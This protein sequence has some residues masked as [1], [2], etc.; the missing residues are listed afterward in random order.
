MELIN[1][2]QFG[3]IP[4]SSTLHAL[5]SM[6]PAWAQATDGTG[7]AVR[8]VLLDY[9]ELELFN[10]NLWKD[11]R[12]K[13]CNKFFEPTMSNTEHKLHHFL[14]PKNHITNNLKNQRQFVNPIMHS[15]RFTQTYVNN[16]A[17]QPY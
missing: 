8:V 3:A 13:Q 2:N 5:I 1:L 10:L 12:T 14:P 9:R 16:H 11:R 15:K 4:K 6:V 17:I 7:S